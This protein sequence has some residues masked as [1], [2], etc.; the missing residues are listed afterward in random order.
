MFFQNFNYVS[1]LFQN[2]NHKFVNLL[3]SISKYKP[4]FLD[5]MKFWGK[6]SN[7]GQFKTNFKKKINLILLRFISRVINFQLLFE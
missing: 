4:P 5:L 6:A 2:G 1:L 3:P 7:L